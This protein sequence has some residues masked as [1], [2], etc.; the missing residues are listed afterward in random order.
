MLLLLLLLLV[1][2]LVLVMLIGAGQGGGDARRGGD[3]DG[4]LAV[5]E[6]TSTDHLRG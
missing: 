3:V 1:L 5:S 6:G 2:L 4:K